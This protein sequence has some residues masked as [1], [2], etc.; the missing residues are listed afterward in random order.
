MF[1]SKAFL[2]KPHHFLVLLYITLQVVFCKLKKK[3]I[4]IKCKLMFV[5]LVRFAYEIALKSLLWLYYWGFR[6]HYLMNFFLLI[7]FLCSLQ[8]YPIDFLLLFI[9]YFFLL[10]HTFYPSFSMLLVLFYSDKLMVVATTVWYSSPF[11]DIL[12]NIY[13]FL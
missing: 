4:K 12:E 10:L 3:V 13:N 5:A 2:Y 6:R 1:Q 7:A 8:N 9:D 11:M